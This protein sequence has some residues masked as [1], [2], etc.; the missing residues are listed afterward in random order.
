M[1]ERA[2]SEFEKRPPTLDIANYWRSGVSLTSCLF[3]YGN[4]RMQRNKRSSV[5]RAV[6][7]DRTFGHSPVTFHP[8]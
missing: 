3:N 8:R 1:Y 7:E 5:D 2:K 4:S 6:G